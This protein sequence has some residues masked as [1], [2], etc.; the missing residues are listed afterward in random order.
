[1]IKVQMQRQVCAGFSSF[2][3]L[4]LLR[5]KNQSEKNF[6]AKGQIKGKLKF[7]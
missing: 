2:D 1:M 5:P 7:H 3:R 4:S 6:L